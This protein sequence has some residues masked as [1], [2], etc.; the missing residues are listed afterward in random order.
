MSAFAYTT[1][2]NASDTSP[3]RVDSDFA[4]FCMALAEPEI[5]ET[6]DGPAWL[7]CTFVRAKRNDENVAAMYSFVIDLDNGTSEDTI[8]AALNGYR[9]V[10]HS[11]YSHTPERPKWRVIVPFKEVLAPA[12]YNAVFEHFNKL[13]DGALDKSCR[14]PSHLYYLPSV[15]PGS[16]S[17]YR[18]FAADGKLFDA[19]KIS[20]NGGRI[21]DKERQV[22]E[23]L[24]VDIDTL[25]LPPTIK[26]LIQADI[27]PGKRSEAVMKVIVGMLK[28][29]CTADTISSVLTDACYPLS[30]AAL[31]RGKGDRARAAK[32]LAPQIK[33]AQQTAQQRGNGAD[34]QHET[35][36]KT[37]ESVN[38][39][40]ESEAPR[41]VLVTTTFAEIDLMP[42][43]WL[44]DQHLP[45]GMV[46]L[47]AGDPGLGKSLVTIAIAAHVT[48]G[49]PWPTGSGVK[50]CEKGSVLFITDEDDPSRVIKHRLLLAGA[51]VSRVHYLTHVCEAGENGELRERFFSLK[52]DMEA[53]ALKIR[54]I[55]DCRCVIID[56]QSSYM[57]GVDTHKNSDVRGLLLPLSRLATDTRAAVILVAHL[58][59]N[60]T[61]SDLYR[62]SGSIAIPG[63]ARAAYHVK[64]DPDNEG[65]R[66]IKPTKNNNG[67]DKHGFAYSIVDSD[68][69]PCVAWEPDLVHISAM[70]SESDAP[71]KKKDAKLWLEE[72]LSA[73]PRPRDEII[74]TAK[75]ENISEATLYRAYRD[76]KIV[77]KR[78]YGKNAEWS[79][80]KGHFNNEKS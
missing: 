15:P 10:C 36:A 14:N 1:I 57:D 28:A 46:S 80:R 65:R 3:K 23:L 9:Y 7:P 37:A 13:F 64:K 38:S 8:R 32:W 52:Q 50:D 78:D 26:A 17:H 35:Q 67:D 61:Q 68:G 4:S 63:V 19:E 51:D 21:P 43:E 42:M 39:E 47:L 76:M 44:W 5:R 22:R 41:S 40:S 24:N 34:N 11:T 12:K 77:S 72:M 31:E 20:T 71:T 75:D 45:L 6:K 29:G 56:P 59:K 54:Q 74:A 79:L 30:S 33:K 62:T 49:A 69:V 66:F 27:A 58:N 48:T 18:Q 70:S 73:G 25:T 16:E 60:T 2:T 55:G 53:M